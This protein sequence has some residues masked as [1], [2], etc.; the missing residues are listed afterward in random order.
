MDYL[1]YTYLAPVSALMIIISIIFT[2]KFVRERATRFLLKFETA[3]LCFITLNYLEFI[4]NSYKSMIILAQFEHLCIMVI[5]ITWLA[6]SLCYTGYDWILKRWVKYIIYLVAVVHV[7]LNFTNNIHHM[8]YKSVGLVAKVGKTEIIA[9]YGIFFWTET[10]FCYLLLGGG[11][12]VI[13]VSYI[14][15]ESFYRRQAL[16]VIIGFLIPFITNVIYIFR[17]IPSFDKD[18]SSVAFA[19]SG[20]FLFIGM[21]FYKFLQVSPIARGIV[22]NDL[23]DIVVILDPNL[24]VIDYN[25]IAGFTFNFNKKKLGMDVED[26]DLGF[27]IDSIHQVNSKNRELVFANKYKDIIYDIS[28]KKLYSRKDNLQAV[29]ISMVDVTYKMN[30]IFELEETNNRL[31]KMQVQLIQNEK[32]ATLGLLSAGVAHEIN[33]P[34][35]YIKSNYNVISRYLNNIENLCGTEDSERSRTLHKNIDEIKD[36]IGDTRKGVL[37]INDVVQYLLGFS[38]TNNR[39]KQILF[40]LNQGIK[41]T[42]AIA[43]NYISDRAVLDLNLGDIP[44]FLTKGNE[45]H[46]VILNLLTNAAHAI[47]DKDIPGKISVK[48]FTQDGRIICEISDS[49]ETIKPEDRDKIFLPF[50]TS[51]TEKEGTGLGLSIS[52]NIIEKEFSGK[53]YLKNCDDKVFRI[54]IPIEQN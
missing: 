17:I 20:V 34:L 42:L 1:V 32:M 45:I 40:D 16:W 8:F 2:H 29:L 9:D 36:I 47:P 26:T 44:A 12:I 50:Y 15:G 13:I 3:V 10:F 48:T 4:S 33:N 49:G 30:L 18:F 38:R 7:I 23:K 6:F 11:V 28:I 25:N 21:F 24:K 39:D 51:K 53:L 19:F 27:Y 37:R 54:E 35:S 5:S 52:R 43:K 22:F 46:Q 31:E 41:N 14:R